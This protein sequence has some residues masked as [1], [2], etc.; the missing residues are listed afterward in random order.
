M[1]R[2]K[3]NIIVYTLSQQLAVE[4]SRSQIR[5]LEDKVSGLFEIVLAV[6]SYGMYLSY[7]QKFE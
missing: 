3:Y 5:S 2:I 6:W 4:D 1:Y 7:F